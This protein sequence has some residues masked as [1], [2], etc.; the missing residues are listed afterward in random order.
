M[1]TLFEFLVE[2]GAKRVAE[3]QEC[4]CSVG[5]HLTQLRL[6]LHLVSCP[7]VRLGAQMRPEDGEKANPRPFCPSSQ[8]WLD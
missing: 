6:L 8:G 7:R 3:A 4:L 5:A 2:T 1:Q